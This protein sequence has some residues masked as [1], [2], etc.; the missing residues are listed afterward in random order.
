MGE[1][2]LRYRKLAAGEGVDRNEFSQCSLGIGSISGFVKLDLC[3]SVVS[4]QFRIGFRAPD[5]V[6]SLQFLGDREFRIS[7]RGSENFYR[8]RIALIGAKV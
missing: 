5:R 1:Y 6:P 2:Q 4:M 7:D 3:I 8:H